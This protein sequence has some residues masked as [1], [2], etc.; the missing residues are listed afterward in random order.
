MSTD[1][2]IQEHHK[3]VVSSTEKR[4]MPPYLL[5]AVIIVAM[6]ILMYCGASWQIFR[7]G[8]DVAKYQCYATAFLHGVQSVKSYP[9]HQCDFITHI[10]GQ[11]YTNAKIAADL[12][13]YGAPTFLVNFVKLQNISY[14]FHALP[15][16]YPMLTL[17]PFLLVIFVPANLYQIAFALLMIVVAAGMYFLLI[18]FKSRQTALVGVALLVIGGWGTVAGR[19]D[20]LPSLLTLLAVILAERKRWTWAFVALAVAFLLKFYPVLL[21]IPFLLAQQTEVQAKWNAWRRWQPLAVF[22]GLSVLVMGVSLLLSVEGTIDPLSYFQT[23]PIQAESFGSSL[24]WLAS[25]VAHRHLTFNFNYHSLNVNL[26]ATSFSLI[27]R[28]QE[29]LEVVGLLYV[30]WLQWKR[31]VDLAAAT[32]LILLIVL[33]TGKIFSPQYIIWVIPLVA[34]VGGT[35]RRWVTSWVVIGALTSFIY[36]FI[37]NMTT[38][39][40]HVPSVPWFYPT[41]TLRNFILLGVVLALLVYYS[42]QHVLSYVAEKGIDTEAVELAPGIR[43]MMPPEVVNTEMQDKPIVEVNIDEENSSNG[44]QKRDLE[45]SPEVTAGEDDSYVS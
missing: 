35:D 17:L 23:R 8:T 44:E 15:H 26:G 4:G 42:R 1:I 38:G 29:L 2:K 13:K 41:V 11:T 14:R 21:L 12:H 30:A 22:I 27:S 40:L 16:E 9:N 39:I 32:L 3:R 33:V 45:N 20:L 36:P 10:D 43:E 28:A 5:D 25:L 7:P 6:G 24:V 31:K 18:R 19:F 37:Y 34:Y